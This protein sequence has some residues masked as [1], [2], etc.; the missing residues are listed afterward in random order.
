Q[1]FENKRAVLLALMAELQARIAAV[2][3]ARPRVGEIPGGARVPIEL[4][5]QFCRRR[6][7]EVLDAVFV[8]EAT[9]RLVLRDARGLD[10]A[11]DEIL[12]LVDRLVL[13]AL[14][15]DLTAAQAAGVLRA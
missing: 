11:V 9:L 10:G 7:R 5:V 15:A 14:E 8:D 6:L 4:V 12:A 1:Y 13:D 2:L 3:A